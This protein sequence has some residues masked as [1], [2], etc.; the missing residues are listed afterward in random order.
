MNEMIFDI[1]EDDDCCIYIV[2]SETKQ[3]QILYKATGLVI[4]LS[5][6]GLMIDSAKY[7]IND[8]R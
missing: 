1:L 2:A 3:G 6:I 4:K 8:R 5:S 7:D